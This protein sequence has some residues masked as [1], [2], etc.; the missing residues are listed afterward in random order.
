[1]HFGVF[2]L[3]HFLHYAHDRGD[4]VR[5]KREG[6]TLLRERYSVVI[7]NVPMMCRDILNVVLI[8]YER[9]V[10]KFSLL[11]SKSEI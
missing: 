11:H 7:K 10:Y 4:N 1:M 8:S 9:M 3:F 5:E 2:A 6:V